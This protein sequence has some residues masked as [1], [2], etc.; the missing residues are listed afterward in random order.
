MFFK[1]KITV[2]GT[3]SCSGGIRYCG[4]RARR[5]YVQK[6]ESTAKKH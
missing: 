1:K 6:P 5:P 2:A 3:L 4:Q